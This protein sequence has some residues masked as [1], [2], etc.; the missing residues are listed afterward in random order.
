[1]Q[2]LL[3]DGN[4][5]DSYQGFRKLALDKKAD[6][7][8]VGQDMNQAIQCLQNLGRIDEVDEFREAVIEVQKGN[9]RCCT[10]PPTVI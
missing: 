10:P 9:W 5:N 7:K 4:W 8:L 2:K 1:M 3:N 6:P